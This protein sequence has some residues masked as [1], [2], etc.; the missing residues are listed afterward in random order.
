MIA[1]ISCVGCAFISPILLKFEYGEYEIGLAMTLAALAS[2]VI[3]PL[4]GHLHDKLSCSRQILL[5]AT[6][7]GCIFYIALVLS[8]GARGI[9]EIAVM[10]LNMTIMSMISLVDA[11]AMRLISEGYSLNYGITRSGGSF[12]YAIAGILFGFVMSSFGVKPGIG[13][14]IVLFLIQSI[15]SLFIPNPSRPSSAVIKP[16]LKEGFRQLV[17]NKP[18]LLLLVTYF[19]SAIAMCS[20][21]SFFAVR[22]KDLGGTEEHVGIGLFLQALSEI[23]IM[24]FFTRIKKRLRKGPEFFITLSL[25]F[26]GLKCIG[27]GIAPTWQIALM[28]TMINGLAFGLFILASVDYILKYVPE[29]LLATAYLVSSSL[30]SSLGAVAGNYIDGVI[31]EHIGAGMMMIITSSFAF[32]SAVF[33]IIFSKPASAGRIKGA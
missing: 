16:G 14:L 13:I 23:P 7:L 25:I 2:A 24:F 26:Y 33:V 6:A 30:G 4:W 3:K 29:N 8:N 32:L 11:W 28:V 5:I 27:M 20:T 31:A 9:T 21:E 22:I 1:A 12:A 19:L 18:Y 10:G 15:V 17:Q